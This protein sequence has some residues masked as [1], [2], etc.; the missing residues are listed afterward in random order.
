MVENVRGGVI[1]CVLF[2][3]FFS[4]TK[5]KK[6]ELMWKKDFY[7]IGSQSS[8]RA[9]DLNKDGVLDIVM[10]GAK[11]ENR[12]NDQGVMALD[13]KTGELLWKQKARDQVFGS[14]TFYDITE[15]GI[16]DVFITGRSSMLM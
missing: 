15:D 14:A 2:L 11:A 1:M 13:G 10:G 9:I 12:P 7:Q 4:C 5:K 3:F 6:S 16:P 8:P